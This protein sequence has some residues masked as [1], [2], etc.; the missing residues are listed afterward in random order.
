MDNLLPYGWIVQVEDTDQIKPV[1][2]IESPNPAKE[3]NDD[4]LLPDGLTMQFGVGEMV[5]NPDEVV[6]RQGPVKEE[7][8]DNLE[9]VTVRGVKESTR[10]RSKAKLPKK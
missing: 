1:R 6:Q 3:E 4:N 7:N 9:R 10:K 5:K 2:V 8:V